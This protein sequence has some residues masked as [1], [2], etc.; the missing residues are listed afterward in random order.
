MKSYK[1]IQK[2]LFVVCSF[3]LLSCSQ[4]EDYTTPNIPNETGSFD[5]SV[6]DAGINSKDPQSRAVTDAEYRTTFVGGD[7]IGLFAVKGGNV[8][9][10]VKNVCLTYDGSKWTVAGGTT[11]PYTA[12]QADADYYVYYPYDENLTSSFAATE[13]DPFANIVSS[14]TIGDDLEGDNYTKKDLMTSAA[15]KATG[16]GQKFSLSFTLTHRMALVVV[17]LPVVTYEFTNGSSNYTIP[18][19]GV[20]F[21]INGTTTVKPFYDAASARYRLLVKPETAMNI[22]GKFT[23]G[24]ERT[25]TIS[26]N[27]SDLTSGKYAYYTIDKESS[28][29]TP[30]SHTL[31]IGDYYCADGSIVSKDDPAPSNAIGIVYQVGTTDAIKADFPSCDHGLVYALKRVEGDAA[32]FG[33][34]RPTTAN[35]HEA[36]DFVIASSSKSAF[37]GYEDTKIWMAIEDGEVDGKNINDIM[38]TT[39][40]NYR[41][42]NSLPANTT[43]WFLLSQKEAISLELNATDINTSLDAVSGERLWVDAVASSTGAENKFYWTSTVRSATTLIQYDPSNEAYPAYINDRFGYY[44]FSFGF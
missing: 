32:K 24:G 9:E 20:S 2:A 10:S 1:L 42:N 5:I 17:E 11:L 37:Q 16:S 40:K 19:S 18:A 4:E 14:W 13:A 21:D 34:A 3:A 30:I 8:L 25:Y 33:S 43:D 35:W 38:K 31:Q 29:S 28:S 6:I 7:Q 36:Y 27:D 23:N 41:A 12:E 22:N 26:L 44:R 15:T 39:L